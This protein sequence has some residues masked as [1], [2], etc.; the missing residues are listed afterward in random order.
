MSDSITLA[1]TGASGAIYGVRLLEQLLLAG[2]T[3]HFL[4]STPARL[5]IKMELSISLPSRASDLK[6]QL[7]EKYSA[8]AE[9]LYVYGLEQW[10]APVASGSAISRAMVICPC[11]S[12][13]MAS[14]AHGMSRN[15]I[16]RAAD[17]SLKERKQLILVHRE[18]PLSPIH[19]QN[20]L[21]LS[22][23]GA[24]ILPASPAF[25]N[26]PQTIQDVTDTVVARILD[27]LNIEHQ[28]LPR[29]GENAQ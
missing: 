12:G 10:T 14:I 22:Q 7:V 9:Q 25:Y 17:V 19:M 15:L 23:A 26:Q 24:I 1:M 3:V 16:E 18:T 28:L 20:M 5:V 6:K 4:L 11:T 29:W 13:T 21:T 8:K 2:K 27:H